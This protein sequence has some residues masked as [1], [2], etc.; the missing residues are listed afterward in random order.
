M[1]LVLAGSAL[2]PVWM[3]FWSSGAKFDGEQS[4]KIHRTLIRRRFVPVLIKMLTE[5][6]AKSK[7][8]LTNYK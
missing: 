5:L 2:Q 4:M 6:M 3:I 7:H 8:P 1:N